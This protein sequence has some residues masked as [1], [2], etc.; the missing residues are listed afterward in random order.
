LNAINTPTYMRLREQLRADIVA[1]VWPLGAHVTLAQLAAHYEVSANPVREALLQ[2]QGEGVVAMRMNRGAVVPMVDAKYIDNLCRVRGAIQ[3]M[4][5][6]EAARNATPAQ[7]DE[8]AALGGAYERAVKTGDAARCVV[9]NRA[10][11][12]AIDA[13]ADNPMALE[14]LDGRSSLMDAFRRQIGYRAG[15]LR[16][17]VVQHRALIA[18]IRAGD[19]GAAERASLAHTDSARLDLLAAQRAAAP[20]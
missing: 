20:V 5:A 3:A 13:V 9:A 14:L 8:I 16:D 12:R 2:L 6:R 7:M 19:E 11:H 17:V 15:R 10:L 18:A 4:T 1:G